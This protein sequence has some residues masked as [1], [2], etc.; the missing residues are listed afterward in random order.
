MLDPS[1]L[2]SMSEHILLKNWMK[3]QVRIIHVKRAPVSHYRI[4]SRKVSPGRQFTGKN[5]RRTAAAEAGRIF[6]I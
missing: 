2:Q 4:A 6:A 3:A 5:A 1:R